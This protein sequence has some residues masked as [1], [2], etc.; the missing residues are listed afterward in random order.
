M[1]QL[2]E[3]TG[4][5]QAKLHR[6]G[7]KATSTVDVKYHCLDA[8]SDTEVHSLCNSFFSANRFYDISGI[9][10]LVES[11]DISHL[12]G[13]VWEVNAHY[14]TLGSDDE[15]AP[16]KRTRQ[17]DTTGGTITQ[18]LGLSERRYGDGAPEMQNAVNWD[19]EQVNGV[20]VMVPA[21]SW[22]ETYDVPSVFVTAAYIRMLA[23]MS[24]TTNDN[25]FRSFARGEVLFV[26]ATGSQQWDNEKGDGPWNLSYKFIAN[27]NQ[28]GTN[29]A[30]LDIG[31]I[32]GILKRGHEFLWTV[33]ESQQSSS[34]TALVAKPK[35]VYVN[36]VY[37]ESNFASLGIGVNP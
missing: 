7:K 22:T 27:P 33:F 2:I 26:G 21:L 19:G 37:R 28:D 1:A 5:R 35:F 20:E 8:T 13:D 24:A 15:G 17:F 34:A 9:L 10:F 14:E 4:S 32:T 30:P 36:Q 6:L 23:T 11:Y 25:V 12:G 16:L 31:D 18:K 3:I 29:L